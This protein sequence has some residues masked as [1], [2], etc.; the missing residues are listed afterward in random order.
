MPGGV[1]GTATSKRVE[2]RVDVRIRHGDQLTVNRGSRSGDD[3]ISARLQTED[4]KLARFIRRRPVVAQREDAL[5]RGQARRDGGDRDA[6]RWRT[7]IVTQDPF[8]G[9]TTP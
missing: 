2:R 9:R 1:R 4:A 8:N 5:A 6:L 3:D 7:P